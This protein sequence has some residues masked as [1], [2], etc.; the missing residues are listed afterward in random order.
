MTG[1]WSDAAREALLAGEA[2]S[3]W[4]NY[5]RGYSEPDLEFLEDLPVRRLLIID[6]KLGHLEPL[7]RLQALEELRLE[8]ARGAARVREIHREQLAKLEAEQGDDFWILADA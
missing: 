4:L 5:A 7:S 6:R 3:L 8:V 1:R 2:E